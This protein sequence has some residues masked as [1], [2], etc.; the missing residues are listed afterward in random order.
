MHIIL[1]RIALLSTPRRRTVRHLK[2]GV[3]SLLLLVNTAVFTIWIPARL[4][5]NERWVRINNVW[6][7]VEKG[8]FAVV[9]VGLNIYFV[10]I[11]RF[12]LV[13]VKGT[14]LSATTALANSLSSN[15]V[16]S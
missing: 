10:Y 8:I 13:S 3:F 15:R 11:V 4:Q 14:H 16:S 2:W 7:R 9:D 12:T 6:D 1:N 5:I